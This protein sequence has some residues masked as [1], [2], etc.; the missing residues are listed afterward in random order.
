MTNVSSP[1]DSHTPTLPHSSDSLPLP[2]TP[3]LPHSH[4][5]ISCGIAGWSYPDW[6]GYVYPPGIKDQLRYIAGYVDMIEINTTFYRPPDAHTAAS[7]VEKTEDLPDFFFTAKIHKDVTHGRMIAPEMVQAFH[8]GLAPLTAKGR[9]R[10]LLAQFKY[11]FD[12]RPEAREHLRKIK[13]AFGDIA[14][15]TLELR[16]N[17]W[18]STSALDFL[19]SLGVTVANLDYPTTKSSFTLRCCRVGEH[20]YLRLHG[21][22]YKAWFD[23]GSGRNETYN[24]L[25]SNQEV[26][27]IVTRALDLAKMSKSL[28]LVANNHYQG[29]EAVNALEVKAMIT[30]RKVR[31]P[32]LLAEKYPQLK[33]IRAD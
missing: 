29:K 7:W 15:L 1:P 17:S 31:V 30:N 27:Q 14:N 21:R 18:Q 26:E 9:L 23:R 22:N 13:E 32:P 24:Y 8:N 2:P 19:R 10:H 12:N 4:T 28:T 25:Y 16:H 33:N 6:E 5:P 3:T 11:D 20:A